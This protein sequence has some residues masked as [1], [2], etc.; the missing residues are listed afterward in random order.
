MME[1]EMNDKDRRYSVIGTILV[2]LGV[3]VAGFIVGIVALVSS[4]FQ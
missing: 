1:E 2:V 3:F 4:F